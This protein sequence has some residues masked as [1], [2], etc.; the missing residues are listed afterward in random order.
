MLHQI[1]FSKKT[2]NSL[3][4]TV[5]SYIYEKKEEEDLKQIVIE[6]SKL[7]TS[8]YHAQA[9]QNFSSV[10]WLFFLFYVIFS[11]QVSASHNPDLGTWNKS[12]TS[13]YCYFL[14]IAK[15]DEFH[16]KWTLVLKIT[17]LRSIHWLYAQ[18]TMC[19]YKSVSFILSEEEL[20]CL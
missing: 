1:L 8:K 6:R 11:I 18:L 9:P 3:W 7:A 20:S 13:G 17:W 5:C 2:E 15:Y 19:Y 14:L 10:L 16:R 12:F 4:G